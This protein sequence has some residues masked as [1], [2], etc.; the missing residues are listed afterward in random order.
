MKK[1]DFIPAVIWLGLGISVTVTS[2]KLKLG[3][4]SDPGPGLMPFLLGIIL[5]ILSLPILVQS[6]SIIKRKEKQRDEGIWSDVEFKKLI[7]VL[8]SLIGYAML[9]E[10]VGF[11]ITTFL[12]ML[13]L[14]KIIS[15]RKWF[16]A[17]IASILTVVTA[18]FLFVELLRVELP[19]GFWR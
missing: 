8:V 1:S 16:F 17:L 19:F 7:I 10:K 3:S 15:T 6:F 14:Y 2:Y 12:L 18:F 4:L 5:S 11:V 9:L 13:I